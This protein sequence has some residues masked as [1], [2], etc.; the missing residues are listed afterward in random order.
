[1]KLTV[2]ELQCLFE[3]DVSKWCLSVVGD[4]T[5]RVQR[6]YTLTL[7][8]SYQVLTKNSFWQFSEKLFQKKT[9]GVQHVNY[10][11]GTSV[12]LVYSDSAYV[13]L[14]IPM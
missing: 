1:M 10:N 11:N 13:L 7:S 9:L 3:I 4:A 12:I 5:N 2:I 6:R 14:H 8:V